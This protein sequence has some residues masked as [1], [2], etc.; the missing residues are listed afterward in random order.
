[1]ERMVK[2]VRC[3]QGEYIWNAV[4][5]YFVGEGREESKEVVKIVDDVIGQILL[6]VFGVVAE[7]GLEYFALDYVLVV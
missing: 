5:G 3:S 4:S 7:K 1:M 2:V 6:D